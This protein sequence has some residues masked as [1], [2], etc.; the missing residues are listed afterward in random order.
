MDP[1]AAQMLPTHVAKQYWEAAQ[2]TIIQS[3]QHSEQF[4][5]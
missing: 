4:L 2:M 5:Q 3:L 1:G